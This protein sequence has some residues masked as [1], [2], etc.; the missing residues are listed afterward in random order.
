MARNVTG[1]W[2]FEDGKMIYEC[3]CGF[4]TTDAKLEDKDKNSWSNLADHVAE[5]HGIDRANLSFS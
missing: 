2:Y 5:E 4:K 3:E 1:Q